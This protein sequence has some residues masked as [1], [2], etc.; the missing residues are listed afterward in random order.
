MRAL[1]WLYVPPHFET[2]KR[3]LIKLGIGVYIDSS[4]MYLF[5]V[6]TDRM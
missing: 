2:T 5:F 3:I 1:R 6:R 4:M